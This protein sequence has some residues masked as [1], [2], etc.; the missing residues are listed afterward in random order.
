MD[1]SKPITEHVQVNAYPETHYSSQT[2]QQA[3]RHALHPQ[4]QKFLNSA[5]SMQ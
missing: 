5:F 2:P 3:D 4:P 1:F